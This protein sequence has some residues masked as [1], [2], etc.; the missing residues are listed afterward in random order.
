[1][2]II[3]DS[4]AFNYQK[5]GGVSR[6]YT[7]IFSVLSRNPDVE[8]IIPWFYTKNIYYKESVLYNSRQKKHN[9]FL[10]LLSKL[11]ISIRKKSKKLNYARTINE[12]LSGSNFD[13]FI[14]TY[15]DPYFLNY[16]DNKPFVLTVYDMIH[17]LFP[18]YFSDA[19]KMATNKLLLIE[20]A[21]KIIAV[22][23]NT[24]ND[25]LRLYPHIEEEK[26]EVVYHGTSINV[27]ENIAV[28]LPSNYILFVGSR[29]DYKNFIFLADAIKELLKKN[30]NLYLVCAGGGNFN[31]AENDL[32]KEIGLE[33]QIIQ[34]DF[35]EEELGSFYKNAKCFVFPSLYEGFGIPVLEAMACG[36]PV[37]LGNHSSFPE[38]A[39]NAG[40]YFDVNSKEDLKNK[41]NDLLENDAL[42]A[43]FAVKGLEQSKKFNWENAA[44]QCL[45]V[46]QKAL[47]K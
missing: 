7:E 23:Q 33:N 19:D 12:G 10:E 47:K 43:N 46:Y 39:G 37:V 26:I 36:C 3:L 31:K 4:Q 32:I 34:K 17:E 40:V 42:R 27:N 13:L 45:A 6:Y 28:D 16:I 11:G 38:V 18:Q 25:I 15:Y 2:K 21:T 9:S 29:A 44:L 41:I 22:S 24:K 30:S 14:P 20:K 5:Y 1:M 35:E 8:V